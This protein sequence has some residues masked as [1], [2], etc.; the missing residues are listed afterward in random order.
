MQ[1]QT[2]FEQL[3]FTTV[4]I[5]ADTPQGISTGTSFV[6]SYTQDDNQY[7]F[8]VTNKHVIQNTTNGRFFF[9]LSD[10]NNPIIGQ[11]FDINVNGFPD[12]WHGHPDDSIDITIMPLGPILQEIEKLGKRVFFRAITHDLVPNSEQYKDL[13]AVEDVI[14]IGYPNGIFD[15]KNLMPVVRRGITASHPQIDYEGKPIFLIDAS[16]FPGS[17]G[18]PVLIANSGSYSSKGNLI[19]GTRIHFLGVVASVAIR[20]EHGKIEFVSI[21]ITQI[22]IVRTRQL[23]NLGFVYKSSAVIETIL[24]FI[25]KHSSNQP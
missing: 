5:E 22:P 23:L 6:F 12:M 3:L 1:V 7:F 20:E 21:P 9:T 10:G 8:L 14:F 17:S 24:D 11:R 16:V 18:S 2:L 4:R 19:V 13:D 15:A 25:K